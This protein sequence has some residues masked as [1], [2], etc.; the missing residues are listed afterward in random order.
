[1]VF[2]V[3]GGLAWFWTEAQHFQSAAQANAG[4]L[5]IEAKDPKVNGTAPT[6]SLGLLLFLG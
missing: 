1:M 6:V 2:F 3:R 4:K 5:V